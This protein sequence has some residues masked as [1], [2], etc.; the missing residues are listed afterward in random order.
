MNKTLI[1]QAREFS[2]AAHTDIGQHRKYTGEPY[3]VHPAMVAGLLA[4][5][6]GI[7]PETV[8]AGYLH[9]VVEDT[10]T[11]I[12]DIQDKFGSEVAR[13]VL[14]VTN[15]KRLDLNRAERHRLEV[16]AMAKQDGQVQNVRLA[17]IVSNTISVA[18]LDPAFAKRY[19]QEKI[20]IVEVMSHA[21]PA[22]KDLAIRVLKSG[23]QVL[24]TP[25]AI[26][27]PK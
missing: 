27:A 11:T 21:D 6:P 22:L 4:S 20:D 12:E 26:N 5:I 23:M 14:Q 18:V 3:F 17:D 2:F 25:P 19:L 24:A 8:A 10:S 9:D 16:E 1:E 7:P 13:I 15:K